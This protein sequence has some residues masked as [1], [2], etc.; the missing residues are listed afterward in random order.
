MRVPITFIFCFYCHFLS[1]V[2]LF[3]WFWLCLSVSLS[4]FPLNFHYKC[5]IGLV[6]DFFFAF[7]PIHIYIESWK[8]R[9]QDWQTLFCNHLLF[10]NHFEDLQNVF[11]EVKLIINNAP[12]TY[13]YSNTIDTYL[14]PNHLLFGRPLLCYSDTA[15][16]VV[17]NLTILPSTTDKIK[18]I[19]NHFWH[20]WRH[21]YVVNL[22]ETQRASKLNMNSQKIILC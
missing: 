16:T 11:I 6:T 20:R 4:F 8:E 7:G 10:C 21:E 17:G 19:S 9:N 2:L 14:T 18:R 22:R 3:R 1:F 5:W 12:L 13:I 15:S